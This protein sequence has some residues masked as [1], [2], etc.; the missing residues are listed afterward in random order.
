M[1]VSVLLARQMQFLLVNMIHVLLS[2]CSNCLEKN[3]DVFSISSNY[4]FHWSYILRIIT[5]HIHYTNL[6]TGETSYSKLSLVDL[7]V[8]E[9]TVEEDRGE[10]ATELLHVMKSLSA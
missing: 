7:A 9:S 3:I 8:S 1:T 2:S 10:H 4:M 5:V 6:I